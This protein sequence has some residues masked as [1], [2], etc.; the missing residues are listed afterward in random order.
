MKNNILK[1][2]IF[3]IVTLFVF[4][5]ISCDSDDDLPVGPT[6]ILNSFC[7]G[8][9][10]ANSFET[11]SG[12]YTDLQEIRSGVFKSNIFLTDENIT[13]GT[14]G[15]LDGVGSLI[16]LNLYGNQNNILQR[17]TYRIDNLEEVG[18]A[19]VSYLIDFDST[20]TSNRGI[21]LVSGYVSVSSY[22]GGVFVEIDGE[23]SNGDRFHGIFYGSFTA[24]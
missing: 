4:S 5:S 21:I 1:N 11:T 17:G 7:Y 16:E 19:G 3:S 24:L 8:L 10:S 22:Q 23:D 2:I 12:F 13:N 6:I 20:S 15:E 14:N 9:D 18:N